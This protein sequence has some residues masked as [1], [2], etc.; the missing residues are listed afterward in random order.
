M[1][2]GFK[3]ILSAL[4]LCTSLL[5]LPSCGGPVGDL[6][7]A[8]GVGGDD[9]ESVQS[10]FG[11]T[12]GTHKATGTMSCTY[13]YLFGTATITYQVSTMLYIVQNTVSHSWLMQLN[14]DPNAPVGS[15]TIDMIL[16]W[17][18][19]SWDNGVVVYNAAATTAYMHRIR[20][21][22]AFDYLR[23]ET[24][25]IYGMQYVDDPAY[26]YGRLALS[27]YPK[28]NSDPLKGECQDA[29]N[30]NLTINP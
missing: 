12:V 9:I 6:A 22:G 26:L 17:P 29:V 28:G 27:L 21:D 20:S 5:A 7:G 8:G 14:K 1:L 19:E 3:K 15:V 30:L 13:S 18:L 4:V 2:H 10:A 24:V 16:S 25:P 23:D 11:V